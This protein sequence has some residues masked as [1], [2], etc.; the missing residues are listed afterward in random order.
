[1]GF[2]ISK[3]IL[4]SNLFGELK[5]KQHHDWIRM[6][7][8]QEKMIQQ[9]TLRSLTQ[10]RQDGSIAQDGNSYHPSPS[11]IVVVP[12][13]ADILMGRGTRFNFH[14]GNI[15]LHRMVDAAIP[16]YEAAR[17]AQ[18]KAIT[19]RL[20]IQEVKQD[21]GGRFLKQDAASGVWQATDER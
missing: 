1:M 15:E 10:I 11:S 21:T 19:Q 2:G 6:R 18:K 13:L 5:L 17:R 3:N 16:E 8:T 14:H 12:S 4:P 9:G 20:V 7:A